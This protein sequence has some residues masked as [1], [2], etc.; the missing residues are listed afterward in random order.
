[1]SFLQ[2]EKWR[3]TEAT[4]LAYGG[5]D[6]RT[7]VLGVPS[8]EECSWRTMHVEPTLLTGPPGALTLPP[9]ATVLCLSSQ[10]AACPALSYAPMLCSGSWNSAG[11]TSLGSGP[12][13]APSTKSFRASGS[14]TGEAGPRFSSRRSVQ[15]RWSS[16][17]APAHAVGQLFTDLGSGHGVQAGG[18]LQLPVCCASQ[19]FPFLAEIIKPLVPIKC[20]WP[21]ALLRRQ[22]LGGQRAGL[23]PWGR[24]RMGS[25]LRAELPSL[26]AAGW[27]ALGRGRNQ[28][29]VQAPD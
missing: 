14:G 25:I 11:P 18:R 15:A 7:R 3:L 21:R 23:G 8:E 2:M 16:P 29:G 26:V 13:S 12:T 6:S 22:V 10:G 19:G 28:E 4:Q 5:T 1:M 27:E 17:P 24:K 9:H 20:P